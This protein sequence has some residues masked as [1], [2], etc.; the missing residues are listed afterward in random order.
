M[1]AAAHEP[2][3][4]VTTPVEPDTSACMTQTALDPARVFPAGV[5]TPIE[6]SM[7]DAVANTLIYTSTL[8]RQMSRSVIAAQSTH[9]AYERLLPVVGFYKPGADL[10][11]YGVAHDGIE[12]P[13]LAQAHPDK[14]GRLVVQ[15]TGTATVTLHPKDLAEL[16]VGDLLCLTGNEYS[17]GLVGYPMLTLPQVKAYKTDRRANMF[18]LLISK[19]EAGTAAG[20]V[21]VDPFSFAATI[22]CFYQG[23]LNALW[24]AQRQLWADMGAADRP[25]T[26]FAQRS[27]ELVA[28]NQQAIDDIRN[29]LTTPAASLLLPQDLQVLRLVASVCRGP[30][31]IE[32]VYNILV[33]YGPVRGLSSQQFA[34]RLRRAFPTQ[35]PFALL[36]E[37]GHNQARILLKPGGIV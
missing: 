3:S 9:G 6:T 8:A 10:E 20:N 18:R 25:L 31:E 37:R 4:T 5:V 26:A 33:T 21:S 17:G 11:V 32:D 15:I 28:A 30:D 22:A 34:D 1:N 24:H 19:A 36:L 7:Y 16:A 12:S 2:V 29:T 23:E 27:A 14:R 35:K 13:Q